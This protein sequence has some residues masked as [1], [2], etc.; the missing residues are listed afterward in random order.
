MSSTEKAK[1]VKVGRLTAVYG[2]KGW[3]KVIHTLNHQKTCLI[4]ED[5][6]G[7]RVPDVLLSGNHAHIKRWRLKQSLGRTW[8]R[9]PDLI[10]AINFTEEQLELL[11]EYRRDL[12]I[13][14]L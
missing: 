7:L 9:R 14:N 1:L 11:T 4:T 13:K 3:L 8:L 12:E 6:D 10:E 5:L 2:V